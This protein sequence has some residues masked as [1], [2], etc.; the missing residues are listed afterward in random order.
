MKPHLHANISAKKYG[1]TP[2]DYMDIH[3]FIDSSK[4]A[5]AD[6][7][8]RAL[9]HSAWG[10]YLVA[11]IFGDTRINSQGKTYSTRDIAE[12]H[13]QQDLGFIPT[14]EH[15]LKNMQL[16]PWMSGATKRRSTFSYT[17]TT[18]E[19]PQHDYVD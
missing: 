5:L 3:E 6:V 18:E 9:L 2:D 17:H 10:V 7:R 14:A 8:H 12:E 1:G 19:A 15:W 13:I 11:R 16:E 4:I